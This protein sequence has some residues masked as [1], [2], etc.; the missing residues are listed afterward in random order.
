MY[1]TNMQEGMVAETVNV[2]PKQ[3]TAQ[4][5]ATGVLTERFTRWSDSEIMMNYSIPLTAQRHSVSRI[6]AKLHL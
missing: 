2:N 5:S 4:I 3:N 6:E 1:Q